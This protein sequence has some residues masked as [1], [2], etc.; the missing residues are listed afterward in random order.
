MTNMTTTATVQLLH[1]PSLGRRT[2]TGSYTATLPHFFF[3]F[4]FFLFCAR[5][6]AM[7]SGWAVLCFAVFMGRL[8][9]CSVIAPP[10][11]SPRLHFLAIAGYCSSQ[12]TQ[13]TGICSIHFLWVLEV[14]RTCSSQWAPAVFPFFIFIFFFN[15]ACFFLTI[16]VLYYFTIVHGKLKLGYACTE[17]MAGCGPENFSIVTLWLTALIF[18]LVNIEWY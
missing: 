16:K 6:V 7:D 2:L 13:F 10:T 3:L 5:Q 11:K 17:K 8:S 12:G 15:K 14:A 4:V 9:L 1:K 18:F